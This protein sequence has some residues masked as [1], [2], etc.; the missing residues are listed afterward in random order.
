MVG[1]VLT[2]ELTG[3]YPL[4][5]PLLTTCLVANLVASFLGGKPIYDQLLARTLAMA[6]ADDTKKP[7]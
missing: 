7:G 5:V 3:T 2:L 1:V 6:A 4:A